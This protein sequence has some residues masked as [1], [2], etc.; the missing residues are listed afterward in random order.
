MCACGCVCR[1]GG[2]WMRI[3]VF[4]NF[5]NIDL[6]LLIEKTKPVFP[7]PKSHK[8]SAEFSG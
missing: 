6:N 7:F 3:V 5:S 2:G 4:V 8:E 1:G